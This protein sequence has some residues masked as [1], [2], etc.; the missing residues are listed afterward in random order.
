MPGS[1]TGFSNIQ[2]QSHSSPVHTGKFAVG[3][4]AAAVLP[5]ATD[6]KPVQTRAWTRCCWVDQ[7][8]HLL[9]GLWLR[10]DQSTTMC[11]RIKRPSTGFAFVKHEARVVCPDDSIARAAGIGRRKETSVDRPGRRRCRENLQ[12]RSPAFLNACRESGVLQRRVRT[13]AGGT[14]RQMQTQLQFLLF[15]IRTTRVA[16]IKHRSGVISFRHGVEAGALAWRRL[17]VSEPLKHRQRSAERCVPSRRSL[18][19]ISMRIVNCETG[20]PE[21]PV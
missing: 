8:R 5:T 7:K 11:T 2:P 17:L 19:M 18:S 20:C 12:D 9:W 13:I 15:T 3:R 14:D 1:T 6:D 16:A 4:R 21:S 10:R